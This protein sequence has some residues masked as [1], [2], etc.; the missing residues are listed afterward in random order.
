MTSLPQVHPDSNATFNKKHRAM[1]SS[2]PTEIHGFKM[3]MP[4]PCNQAYLNELLS[5]LLL[6]LHRQVRAAKRA[7]RRLRAR[8]FHFIRTNRPSALRTR[9]GKQ[10]NAMDRVNRRGCLSRRCERRHWYRRRRRI[11]RPPRCG[12]SEERSKED[13]QTDQDQNAG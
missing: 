9:R 2:P 11:L 4:D 7:G 8:P 10:V 1:S 13:A 3:I 6:L 5:A 12:R